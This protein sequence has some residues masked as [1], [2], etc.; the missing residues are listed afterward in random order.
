MYGHSWAALAKDKR[1]YLPSETDAVAASMGVWEIT[2]M[3]DIDLGTGVASKDFV[4]P[5]LKASLVRNRGVHW[6]DQ[7]AAVLADLLNRLKAH[8]ISVTGKQVLAATTSMLG[9]LPGYKVT[10]ETSFSL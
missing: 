7:L 3:P 4:I 5:R 9:A 2:P 1:Y 10:Y 8:A 6:N